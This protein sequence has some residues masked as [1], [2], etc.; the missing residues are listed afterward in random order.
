MKN[1]P[2]FP[3]TDGLAAL[4]LSEIP[5]RG[6]AYVDVRAVFGS[7]AGL[8]RE[9]AAFCRAAGAEKIYCGGKANFSGYPVYARLVERVISRSALPQTGAVA[10][11]TNAEEWAALYCRRFRAVPA[12]RSYERTPAGE[13]FFIFDG[14]KRIGLGQLRGDTLA[15]L[16][17]LEPGRGADCV[18][19]L[20]ARIEAPAVRLLCAEEN[21]SAMRLYDRLGFSRGRTRE[22]WYSLK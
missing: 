17:S 2:L 7:L 9:C 12:A 21:T 22:V 20:A 18:S 10:V 3:C 14:E 19:A 4:I 16:A 13:A 11:P 6:E 5:T 1:I 15:A 8:L